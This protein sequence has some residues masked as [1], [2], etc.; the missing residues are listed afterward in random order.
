MNTNCLA[1]A[2]GFTITL[3]GNISGYRI[4]SVE[5]GA[6]ILTDDGSGL[7]FTAMSGTLMIPGV[8]SPTTTA[9]GIGTLTMAGIGMRV[10]AGHRHGSIGHGT[11]ATT[12]GVR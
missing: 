6:P 10:I 8:T 7:L 4:I 9:G 1:A 5:I 3:T 12:D 11:I 2:G